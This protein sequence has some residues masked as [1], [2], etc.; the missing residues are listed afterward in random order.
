ML[1]QPV[2]QN[3][4]TC[5]EGILYKFAVHWKRILEC[6]MTSVVSF[7]HVE[8][9][10]GQASSFSMTFCMAISELSNT[11]GQGHF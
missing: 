8:S 4:L 11:H 6:S 1:N 3:R 2:S 7:H 5:K 9:V 10:P